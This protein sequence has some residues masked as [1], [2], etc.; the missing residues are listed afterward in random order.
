MI[1]ATVEIRCQRILLRPW[2]PGDEEALVRYANNREIWK[3]LRDRF[4]HPFTWK[5]AEEWIALVK[6][7]GNPPLNFAIL[8]AG[9]PIGGVGLERLSDVYR[10]TAEVGYWLGEPFW[11]R[12]LATEAVQTTVSYAFDHFDFERLQAGVYEW[13]PRS[14]RVLERAGFKC[15]ARLKRSVF[16]GGRLL[17]SLLYARLRNE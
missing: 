7:Q 5:D 4:P 2:R 9:E 16:K 13:N 12:G 10:M 11:G 1:A 3:N 17:D 14:C 6:A 15:E 8:F